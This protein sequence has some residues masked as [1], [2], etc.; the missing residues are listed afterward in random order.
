MTLRLA[1]H[2][3]AKEGFQK[4]YS[5]IDYIS[6]CELEK[7]LVDIVYLRVSQMNGCSYCIDLHWKDAIKAG[8]DG[9]KLN[10]VI[11]WDIVPFFSDRERAALKWAE[12]MIGLQ[13]A[14]EY[15]KA[16]DLL[17]M[18]FYEKEICDLTFAIAQMN[19]LNR[20]AI[21]FNKHAEL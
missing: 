8:I 13:A 14:D 16:Y 12:V 6:K 7:D 21:S 2:A 15:D 9:R 5:V 17:K 3:I 19:A 4:I 20:I 11:C 18:H 10:G 1:Y